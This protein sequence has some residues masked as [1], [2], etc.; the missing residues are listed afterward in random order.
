M[1]GAW[2]AKGWVFLKKSFRRLYFSILHCQNTLTV[3]FLRPL[4]RL[5]S[6]FIMIVT[7]MFAACMGSAP[8]KSGGTSE[9]NAESQSLF[10]QTSPEEIA[11]ALALEISGQHRDLQVSTTDGRIKVGDSLFLEASITNRVVHTDAIILELNIVASH[12]TLFAG[13]ISDFLAGSGTNDSMA[14]KAGVASYVAGVFSTILHGLTSEHQPAQDFNVNKDLWHP[15]AGT[16]QVQGAFA[17]D[18]TL[19]DLR[20]LKLLKPLL[21]NKLSTSTDTTLHWVKVYVSRQVNGSITQEC[22]YDNNPLPEGNAILKRYAENW[23]VNDFAGQKQ[24]FMLRKCG[25]HK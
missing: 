2:E 19:D 24:F 8:S 1:N 16:L 9:V 14:I 15:V 6:Y 12:A 25:R 10:Q 18:T 11:K 20:F 4:S 22:E 17:G 13:G 5:F 7:V 3:K 21:V 23:K